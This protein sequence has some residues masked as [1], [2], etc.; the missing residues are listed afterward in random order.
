VPARAAVDGTVCRG[1]GAGAEYCAACRGDLRW[2]IEELRAGDDWFL[3]GELIEAGPRLVRMLSRRMF[4][5]RDGV[6]GVELAR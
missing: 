4:G 1:P 2:E 6:E 5:R 3:C